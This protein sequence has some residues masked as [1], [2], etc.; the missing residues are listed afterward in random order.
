M[1]M[2]EDTHLGRQCRLRICPGCIS[3]LAGLMRA[4]CL[5]ICT[6]LCSQQALLQGNTLALCS[7]LGLG[8]LALH[9]M[10]TTTAPTK[11][12]VWRERVHELNA[13][14]TKHTKHIPPPP[15]QTTLAKCISKSVG[16]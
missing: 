8:Q 2:N 14:T 1:S 12:S 4:V 10:Q 5:G 11:T 3:Q 7:L 16:A 15:K 9:G 6:T 13:H